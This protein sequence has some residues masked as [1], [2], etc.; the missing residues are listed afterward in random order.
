MS[1]LLEPTIESTTRALHAK[2]KNCAESTKSADR[3]DGD[4][5]G[6]LGPLV[7][8]LQ[9]RVELIRHDKATANSI[10]VG[11]SV[12]ESMAEN[13]T[14]SALVSALNFR[15]LSDVENIK[16][17][18]VMRN[19]EQV[20]GHSHMQSIARYLVSECQKEKSSMESFDGRAEEIAVAVRDAQAI[21]MAA[22]I[23]RAEKNHA[24]PTKKQLAA[25][26]SS[27]NS[28]IEDDGDESTQV[29]QT[30]RGDDPGVSL[31]LQ[32]QVRATALNDAARAGSSSHTPG[33]LRWYPTHH[34]DLD[35]CYS[36][37]KSFGSSD[38]DDPVAALQ[39]MNH[40]MPG[41]IMMKLAGDGGSVG[42]SETVVVLEY[43][44]FTGKWCVQRVVAEHESVLEFLNLQRKHQFTTGDVTAQPQTGRGHEKHTSH[45]HHS[46]K[47]V[48]RADKIFQ[49]LNHAAAY[50]KHYRAPPLGAPGGEQHRSVR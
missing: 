40:I 14:L 35:D 4:A 24:V 13:L 38:R 37:N 8:G 34:I 41:H 6:N 12:L 21:P 43:D 26:S 27:H 31:K 29:K 28:I 49:H 39:Q 17:T 25:S 50:V 7:R 33:N 16:K 9:W 44:G 3:H 18:A 46:N 48:C 36:C 23:L 47:E 42:Y 19:A 11:L 2:N 10:T 5:C 20:V 32:W 15:M 45:R 22:M 1:A 30:Q